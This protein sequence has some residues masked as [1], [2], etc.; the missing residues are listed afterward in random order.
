[1]PLQEIARY[2]APE[3]VLALLVADQRLVVAGVR[4]TWILDLKAGTVLDK[5]D[6]GSG[7]ILVRDADQ[8]GVKEL[9]ICNDRGI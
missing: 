6:I 1:M 2:D 7:A 4:K 8:D 9:W 3:E 5:L